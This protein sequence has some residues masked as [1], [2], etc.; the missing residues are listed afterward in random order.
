VSD[1]AGI[2]ATGCK[3]VEGRHRSLNAGL[4]QHHVA[5]PSLVELFPGLPFDQAAEP[6]VQRCHWRSCQDHAN[7]YRCEQFSSRRH[8]NSTR[9]CQQ[10]LNERR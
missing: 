9:N 4:R 10:R 6:N 7:S 1:T 3:L 5:A 2:D 8:Q